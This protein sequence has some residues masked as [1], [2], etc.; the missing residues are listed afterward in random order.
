VDKL[1][2]SC[3]LQGSI[4]HS[5]VASLFASL[6]VSVNRSNRLIHKEAFQQRQTLKFPNRKRRF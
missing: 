1:L 3:G 6:L 2:M 4:H 5:L